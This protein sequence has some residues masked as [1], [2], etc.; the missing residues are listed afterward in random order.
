[1]SRVPLRLGLGLGPKLGLGLKLGF[2]VKP[3][4]DAKT[5]MTLSRM[6][7]QRE[8]RPGNLLFRR[9]RELTQPMN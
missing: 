3:A 4:A 8:P 7:P 1:M 6:Q 9:A 2:G 5:G